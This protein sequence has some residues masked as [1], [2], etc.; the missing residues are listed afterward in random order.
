MPVPPPA[1]ADLPCRRPVWDAL[2]ELFLD[3][4]PAIFRAQ[5]IDRLAASPYSLEALEYILTEELYPVC[6]HNL[7]CV[8]GE[9]A[10]FD[11]DWLE[12]RI[13]HNQQPRRRW[14]RLLYPGRR[15]FLGDDEWQATRA[16]IVAR[17]AALP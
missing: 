6:I 8:A 15:G 13:L 5:R 7:R 12:T 17:R 2:S 9:W 10:A 16:G 14:R 11:P 4:D 1:A 3:T